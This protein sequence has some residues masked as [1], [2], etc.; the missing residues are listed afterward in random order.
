MLGHFVNETLPDSMLAVDAATNGKL[1]AVVPTID[2]QGR[3]SLVLVDEKVP[4]VL[5]TSD[6]VAFNATMGIVGYSALYQA[7]VNHYSE[8]DWAI[9]LVQIGINIGQIVASVYLGRAFGTFLVSNPAAGSLAAGE[10]AKEI[11][12]ELIYEQIAKS[13]SVTVFS[14]MGHDENDPM[15]LLS[16]LTFDGEFTYGDAA[17][18]I[19]E[20]AVGLGESYQSA[21]LGAIQGVANHILSEATSMHES[22]QSI[23]TEAIEMFNPV[24]DLRAIFNWSNVSKHPSQNS[25][26][27]ECM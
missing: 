19:G 9:N 23:S 13:V 17:E 16:A 18:I 6:P 4:T 11:V 7:A 3:P 15:P 8:A 10:F 2:M 1:G 20:I 5:N 21:K 22:G 27:E 25:L 12:Q 14:A 26:G 24:W